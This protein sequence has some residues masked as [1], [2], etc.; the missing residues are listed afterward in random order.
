MDIAVASAGVNLTVDGD[1]VVISAR[2]AL[3]AVG[4]TVVLVDA[5]A[6][7]IVLLFLLVLPIIVFQYYQGKASEAS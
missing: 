3:G 4:P 7:A 6:V 2:I 1:G 5:A